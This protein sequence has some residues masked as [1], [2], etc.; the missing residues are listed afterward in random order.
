LA[1]LGQTRAGEAKPGGSEQGQ[2]EVEERG[3]LLNASP[4]LQEILSELGLRELRDIQTHHNGRLCA[5][6]TT[7][8]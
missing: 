1:S 6:P 5:Q 2:C 8:R 4:Q 7:R 3:Q